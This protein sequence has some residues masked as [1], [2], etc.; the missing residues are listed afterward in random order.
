MGGDQVAAILPDARGAWT[1]PNRDPDD[2]G[3]PTEDL[4]AGARSRP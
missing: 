4:V 3:E 2:H 1:A